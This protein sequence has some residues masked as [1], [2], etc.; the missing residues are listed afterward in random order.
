MDPNLV[1]LA[2]AWKQAEAQL[3]PEALAKAAAAAAGSEDGEEGPESG[4]GAMDVDDLIEARMAAAD[5]NEGLGKKVSAAGK[6]DKKGVSAAEG[7]QEQPAAKKQKAAGEGVEAGK[8]PSLQQRL[9]A[10][11]AEG[12]AVAKAKEAEAVTQLAFVPAP[13]WQG[14]RPGYFFSKGTLGLGYYLDNKAPKKSKAGGKAGVLQQQQQQQK[15]PLKGKGPIIPVQ[16][17]KGLDRF[18]DSDS[19][20]DAFAAAAHEAAK[21]ADKKAAAG[22]G[23]G[24]VQHK[25]ALPGRLRKKL[26][27]ERQGKGA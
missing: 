9:E 25:K 21:D 13:K 22:G 6:K 20:D 27:K 5:L 3:G 8:A 24:K 14:P 18:D 2:E 19:D 11:K 12:V 10:R 4:D 16:R 15:Q 1:Q 26:A 23:A 7:A 17:R